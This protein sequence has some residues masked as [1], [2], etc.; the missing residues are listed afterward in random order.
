MKWSSNLCLIYSLDSNSCIWHITHQEH[1]YKSQHETILADLNRYMSATH[2]VIILLD[3]A[4]KH[5]HAFGHYH[6]VISKSRTIHW[7]LLSDFS[8]F[9]STVK[10]KGKQGRMKG[11]IIVQWIN[12]NRNNKSELAHW[13][14]VLWEK[15]GPILLPFVSLTHVHMYVCMVG[16][17][18][19]Y[20]SFEIFKI[21][22]Q[23]N[24]SG[25]YFV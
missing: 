11:P 4:I 21:L 12:L 6:H 16:R 20:G 3:D 23:L 19:K 22:Y 2:L 13:Y 15:A 14:S 7:H 24:Y 5:T 10:G 9:C 18:T 25:I 17:Q 8:P 1:T